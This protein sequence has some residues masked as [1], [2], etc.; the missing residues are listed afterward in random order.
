MNAIDKVIQVVVNRETAEE[1]FR[2]MNTTGYVPTCYGDTRRKRLFIK[3]L[4][5][6][7]FQVWGNKGK[8]W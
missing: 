7:G 4:K 3:I 8:N 6:N 1:F 5:A 2:E